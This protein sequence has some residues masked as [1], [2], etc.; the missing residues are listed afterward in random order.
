MQIS[1][2]NYHKSENYIVK[3]SQINFASKI[4]SLK[5]KNNRYSPRNLEDSYDSLRHSYNI[6]IFNYRKNQIIHLE[7]QQMDKSQSIIHF[8]GI[9]IGTTI[10]NW[11]VINKDFTS[12][13]NAAI[14]VDFENNIL[15]RLNIMYKKE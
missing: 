13:E 1:P 11:K 15:K 7:T 4:D 5:T 6:Y 8:I 2:G 9:N 12:K 10:G 3:S 14:L